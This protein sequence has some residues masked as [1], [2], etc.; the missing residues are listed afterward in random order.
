MR[1]DLTSLSLFATVAEERNI[2]RAAAKRNIAASAVS[3][4]MLDLELA[5]RTPLLQRR[6][7][8]VDLTPAGEAL[9]RH[10]RNLLELVGRI[11]ADMSA[12]ASGHSGQVRL[13]A[14]QS[15][16]TQFL[17]QMLASF[18][19]TYPDIEIE[20]A[21]ATTARSLEMLEDGLADLAIVGWGD[22]H[23]DMTYIPFRSDN[24]ALAV[25]AAHPLTER[26]GAVSFAEA[27]GFDFVGLEQGSSIQARLNA[28]AR[29]IG[30]PLRLKLSMSSFEGIRRMVE[31]G[32]GIA[33]LPVSAIEPYMS[34]LAIQ[35][36]PLADSWARRELRIVCKDLK[37]L[38]LSAALL[39]SWLAA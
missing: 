10:A 19:A 20:L 38:P 33:V 37:A 24:L 34:A 22:E 25:P 28:A 17:P 18:L 27:L 14:N 1:V 16:I 3:K 4:R 23:P 6:S 9:A 8:G 7:K 29:Q 5:Y 12:F 30:Q 21:E 2:A 13:S 35:P 36:V 31:A 32:I 39:R 26:Q 15:A 11:G